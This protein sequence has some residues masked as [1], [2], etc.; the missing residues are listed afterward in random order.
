ML[1]LYR[2]RP[3]APTLFSTTHSGVICFGSLSCRTHT[4]LRLAEGALPRRPHL[5][6]R[7]KLL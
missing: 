1:A 4:I 7:Y 2:E 5:R 3:V 6:E